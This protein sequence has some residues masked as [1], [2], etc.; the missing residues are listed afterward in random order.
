[1][2]LERVGKGHWK[3]DHCHPACKD[4][5]TEAHQKNYPV[6]DYDADSRDENGDCG[7]P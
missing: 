7:P 5:T 3:C 6:H 2:T 4:F 1:M